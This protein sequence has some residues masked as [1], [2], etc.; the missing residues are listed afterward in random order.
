[1]QRWKI[2]LP[3]AATTTTVMLL[4]SSSYTI[5]R[6]HAFSSSSSFS[7]PQWTTTTTTTTNNNSL[8]Q[9]QLAGA[10]EAAPQSNNNRIIRRIIIITDDEAMEAMERLEEMDAKFGVGVGASKERANLHAILEQWEQRE[11][12]QDL[13]DDGDYDDECSV[14][15]DNYD[16]RGDDDDCY[17]DDDDDDTNIY[18]WDDTKYVA[19]H[20]P[21]ERVAVFGGDPARRRRAVEK[22]LKPYRSLDQFGSPR[23]VGSGDTSNLLRKIRSKHYDVVYVWT[24]FNCHGSR[25]AIRDACL[26]TGTTRFFEVESLAYIR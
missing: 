8:L 16:V 26:Q 21:N 7:H 4:L 25:A 9:I 12:Q 22:K 2:S 19:K 10:E 23:D 14:V 18:Y 24:R 17:D 20:S 13:D 11:Q 1:M 15:E 3:L 5:I 6:I